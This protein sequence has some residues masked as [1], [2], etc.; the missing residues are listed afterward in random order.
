MAE[1]FSLRVERVLP[2]PREQVFRAFTEPDLRSRWLRPA[3]DWSVPV[4]ELEPRVGGRYRD[5]F[6]SPDGREF[7]E[8]GCFHEVTPPERLVYDC[9]FEG[10]GVL[11]PDMR[12]TVSLHELG[13]GETQLV[14]VQA[15]YR[16]RANR[17][18][19]ERGWPDF[20][21]QLARALSS[22]APQQTAGAGAR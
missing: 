10:G 16:E 12:V 13:S 17:D 6:R 22:D 15:G 4:T 19:Q 11:E 8:T 3:A 2:F 9:R 5:V 20:L 18:D 1:T 7:S 14:V 21:E